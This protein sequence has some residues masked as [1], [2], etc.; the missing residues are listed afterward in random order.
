MASLAGEDEAKA[1]GLAV[2]SGAQT[3]AP[4][5]D[6]DAAIPEVRL[7]G[8]DFDVD[9]AGDVEADVVVIGGGVGHVDGLAVH[10]NGER[11][12]KHFGGNGR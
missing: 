9:R 2:T 1:D 5:L 10:C 3:Q 11:G 7:G 4:R 8:G 6:V 12:R